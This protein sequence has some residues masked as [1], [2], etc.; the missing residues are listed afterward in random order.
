MCDDDD[1]MGQ[2]LQEAGELLEALNE[3]LISLESDSK[4]SDTL[5]TVFRAFHTIK[6]GAGFLELPSVSD[7]CHRSEDIF[8]KIRS[9]DRDFTSSD[10]DVFSSV[11]D[12]LGDSFEVLALDSSAKLQY[13]TALIKNLDDLNQAQIDNTCDDSES[14]E[15]ELLFEQIKNS[16]GAEDY[17]KTKDDEYT[18]DEMEKLFDTLKTAPSL[19]NGGSSSNQSVSEQV[20]ECSNQPSSKSTSKP[21][22]AEQPTVRV[23]TAKM[24][25]IVN[26]VGELVL[27]RNR[28]KKI[29][30]EIEN[31]ELIKGLSELNYITS[32]LQSA[33]MKTRM[34]PVKRVFQRFPRMVRDVSRGLGKQV[35]LVV[36]GE[37]TEL[38][39]NLVDALADPLIHMIRNSVDHGI[40]MPDDRSKAGKPVKGVVTLKAT[41]VGDHVELTI[42]DDGKGIDPAFMRTKCV[43]K[44][45]ISKEEADS[46]S[47]AD[48][49]QMIFLPG[50]STADEVTDLSGRGVGMD[51]VKTSLEALNG[52]VSIDSTPGFGTVFTMKIPLTMAILQT[53]MVE[54]LS[55]CYA[56]P[57]PSI[58]EI[59]VYKEE[60]INEVDG[61]H[62]SRFRGGSIPIFYMSDLFP[63]SKSESSDSGKSLKIVVVSIG[64]KQAGLVVENVLGQEEVVIK[65]MG[66]FLG[67]MKGYAGATITGNGHVALI[68][69]VNKM[70][71]LS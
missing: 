10:M 21:K 13:P 60:M 27:N 52:Y 26:L 55:Q 69:D 58:V 66:A 47:D 18:D 23:D 39:K 28:L 15:M 61:Q 68:L 45:L 36:I 2:F 4:D 7:L 25:G 11:L 51:V 32:E 3:S 16:S 1:L 24:D 63:L 19:S 20:S 40:E 38:D 42:S 8:S 30:A 57:L 14:D 49:L 29:S 46:I 67:E 34:Q 9:G 70:V 65:P 71:S 48:A 31:T 64:D 43:E 50:F 54:S 44:G 33:V 56:I 53:L 41:Q 59:F 22:K 35:E 6:G 37:D 12:Y 17:H 5:N 62:I